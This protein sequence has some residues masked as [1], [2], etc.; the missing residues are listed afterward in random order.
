MLL[1]NI[2]SYIPQTNLKNTNYKNKVPPKRGIEESPIKRTPS[3]GMLPKKVD[4]PTNIFIRIS[5]F[6][7]EVKGITLQNKSQ[8]ISKKE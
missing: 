5:N 7:K 2:N 1:H 8:E 3:F 4:N 6:L